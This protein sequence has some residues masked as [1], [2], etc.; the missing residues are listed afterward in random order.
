[1]VIL[2]SGLSDISIYQVLHVSVTE[3]TLNDSMLSFIS[4]ANRDD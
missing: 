2:S 3:N 1:M 4:T